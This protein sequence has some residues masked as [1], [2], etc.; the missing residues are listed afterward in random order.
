MRRRRARK[1]ALHASL[2][3]PK[4]LFWDAVWIQ[5][6]DIIREVK[7]PHVAPCCNISAHQLCVVMSVSALH[8]HVQSKLVSVSLGL[9]VE[10]LLQ[11]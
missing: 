8:A 5:P 9:A 6:E 3:N 2:K 1:K 10:Q 11:A 4:D 7:I